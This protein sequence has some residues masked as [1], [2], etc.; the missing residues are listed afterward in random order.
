[1]AE[2]Q[3]WG[4]VERTKEKGL[5]SN[6]ETVS[7][8]LRDKTRYPRWTEAM[9]A[10]LPQLRV[11]GRKWFQMYDKVADERTLRLAWERID[12]RVSGEAR[13]RGAGVDGVTAEAFSRIADKELPT[14]AAAL[15]EGRYRPAPVKRQWI[16]KPGS[17]RK[18][19]LGLP[20]VADRVVQE[21]TRGMI[22]PI[23]EEQ[24]L[25]GSHGFRPGRSTDTACRLLE[26]YLSSGRVWIV[27]ADITG[28]FD[29]I[30]HEAIGKLLNRHIADGK[31]RG[32]VESMLKAGVME[33]WTRRSVV[34][35]TPQGG[36]ISPLL[37]N[38]TLHE[39]DARL[40]SKGIKWVRYADDFVLACETREQAEA[41]LQV[42]AQALAPLGLELHPNKTR[43][44]H[45]EEGFDFLGWRYQGNRRWPRKKSE[46]AI[47]NRIKE[48]TRR[49]RPGSMEKICAELRPIQ[50]GVF[51]YFRNGNSASA[52]QSMDGHIRR[53]LRSILKKRE[54][55]GSGGISGGLDHFKWP[56]A[57]FEKAG[58]LNLKRKHASFR[59]GLKPNHSPAGG[60]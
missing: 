9:V 51:N 8:A 48:K 40:E 5:E 17:A 50:Q 33:G 24:F 4:R 59:A 29:N 2:D 7:G 11:E 22:E 47:R 30:S 23:W 14:L 36:V 12:M 15:K 42:A 54:K 56:N 26:S 49:N 34:A 1:M 35:G 55:S 39:M 57:I 10:A 3:M 43:I 16:P 37:C 46:K 60:G 28:C 41:A 58:L 52:F 53:R 45:L 19:P 32:L 6:P 18:R 31:M 20:T 13:R 25:D 44:A 27:D 21:A 38:I